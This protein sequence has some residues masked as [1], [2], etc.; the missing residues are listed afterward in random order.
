MKSNF[1]KSALACLAMA[2]F[3]G[4]N[5]ANAQ[6]KLCL[7]EI[8]TEVEG[9]YNYYGYNKDGLLD[10]TYLYVSYYDEELYYLFKYDD[11][12]N[13]TSHLGYCI[14]PSEDLDYREF[15]KTFIIEY[16][17]DENNRIIS[18]KNFNLD[19]FSGTGEYLLG[20]MYK[21][22]YDDNGVLT[23][24]K[25]FWDE[26]GTDLF[27]TTNYTYDEKGRVI[28]E[29]Y[30]QNS[31]G[32]QSEQMVVNYFY[33]EQNGKIE[34]LRTDV[35]NYNTGVIEEDDN[36]VYAYDENNNLISR[37]A[38]GKNPDL[39][40]EEHRFVYYTDIKAK[41]VAMPLNKEDVMDFYVLSEN[42]VK[43]DSIYRR[44][45]E[46]TTFDLFDVQNWKY[47]ELN[48]T[49]GIENVFNE[50]NIMSVRRDAEGNLI[51]CGV[52]NHENIRIYDAQGRIVRNG[53][54]NGKVNVEGLPHG[55][56]IVATRQGSVKI[57]K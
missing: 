41:D 55:M 57:N 13:L 3:L 1:T 31:F 25:L 15:T 29:S 47:N 37:K 52:E 5:E 27:E 24:R 9:D 2:L 39:L 40:N 50:G 7:Q 30:L 18:R 53:A 22:Y 54:Y 43:Q 49:D 38:Y 56:Y 11:K 42:V 44:D 32:V 20:G 36:L 45:V 35:M 19:V 8:E 6:K 14:L 23:Q 10:S 4:G 48:S 21:F 51:L 34:R 33:N 16:A 28:K 17:Y 26:A 46:G 12:G